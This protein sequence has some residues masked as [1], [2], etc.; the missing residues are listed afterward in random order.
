MSRIRRKQEAA[1]DS[2]GKV[3]I[4]VSPPSVSRVKK[5]Y[6]NV[7]RKYQ[8]TPLI[9][10]IVPDDNGDAPAFVR[11]KRLVIH[12]VGWQGNASKKKE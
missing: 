4:C 9:L 8:K 7:P 11:D 1:N 5:H 12:V 2:D 10:E 3:G 6:R